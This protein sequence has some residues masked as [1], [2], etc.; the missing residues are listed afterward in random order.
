MQP[1]NDQLKRY[2]LF[3]WDVAEHNPL[4]EE[5]VAWYLHYARATGGPVLDL[6][7]GTG[8]LLYRMAEEGCP[9]TGLDLLAA[10]ATIPSC[11]KSCA[12]AA[13]Q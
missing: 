3:G 10:R 13:R 6:A 7:C 5:E 12:Q 4:S 1:H 8:R 2:D 11:P 9:A